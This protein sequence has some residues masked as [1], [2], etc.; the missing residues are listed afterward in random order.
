MTMIKLQPS[1]LKSPGEGQFS[2]FIVSGALCDFLLLGLHI[3]MVL[4]LL[5]TIGDK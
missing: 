5:V 2:L 3:A 4:Y 1:P